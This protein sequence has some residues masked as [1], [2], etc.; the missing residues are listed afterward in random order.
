MGAPELLY[1]PAS[2]EDFQCLSKFVTD[3]CLAKSVFHT[4]YG[5]RYDPRIKRN[6]YCCGAIYEYIE[7]NEIC[8]RFC[9]KSG[10]PNPPYGQYPVINLPFN[11]GDAGRPARAHLGDGKELPIIPVNANL[12][13]LIYGF[14][15]DLPDTDHGPFVNLGNDLKSALPSFTKFMF[16][17]LAKQEAEDNILFSPIGLHSVLTLLSVGSDENSENR[18]ELGRALGMTKNPNIL[19]EQYKRLVNFIKGQEEIEYLNT[20]FISSLLTAN[21]RYAK[22]IFKHFGAEVSN[23]YQ[24]QL[25]ASKQEINQIVNKRT[26]GKI[27]EVL[28]DLDA[29]TKMLM[30]NT[31]LFQGRWAVPFQE[32]EEKKTFTTTNGKEQVT[33]MSAESDR[34]KIRK[35]DE[36]LGLEMIKIPYVGKDGRVGSYE[37]RIVTAPEQ[38]GP[39]GLEVLI[40][41]MTRKELNPFLETGDKD[42]EGEVKLMMP[43]VSLKKRFDVS[44]YLQTIGVKK[45]FSDNAEL[46]N[47]AD[48]TNEKLTVSQILQETVLTIDTHGTESATA[49][50]VDISTFSAEEPHIRKVDRP[51]VLMLWDRANHIPLLVGRINNPNLSE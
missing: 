35:L 24:D 38:F 8:T 49:T 25:G 28:D 26:K 17:T 39:K 32:L 10:K 46:T 22:T 20:I 37:L 18:Q 2:I 11:W 16:L 33:M 14:E 30:I 51:F 21:A 12:S 45:L 15:S 44:E 7:Y 48:G 43:K 42:L 29:S 6:C 23:F 1:D 40:D 5:C 19:L 34:I 27:P 36:R 3:E 9:L 13:R 31:L 41:S 4:D 50:V 47:I